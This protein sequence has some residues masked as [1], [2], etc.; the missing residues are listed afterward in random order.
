MTTLARPAYHRLSE[1][2]LIALGLAVL[3]VPTFTALA[4]TLWQDEEYAHGP[5]VLAIVIWMLWRTREGWLN[6]TPRPRPVQ[7]WSSLVF[8]LL[9]YIVGRSQEIVI[10][11]VG[12]MVPIL[13]GIFLILRGW[14]S[15]SAAWF[16]L[17]FVAFLV[18]VPSFVVDS[19]TGPLKESVSSIAETVLYTAGY[20]I[21]H[22]G[23]TLTIGQYQL[24]VAD[25]CSG[26]HSMFSL[27][28][29]GLLYIY[30][31]QYKQWWR[32][33]IL[34]TTILPT[35]F[36]ANIVRVMILVLVTYHFGDEAGQGFVHGA[37]GM[38]LFIIALL[39]LIMLDGLIGTMKRLATGK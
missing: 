27:S 6:V 3:Y 23:V 25:A 12:S 33:A 28:A 2:S 1:W 16:P 9:T 19:V 38:V 20:P 14:E 31:M 15:V 34:A 21:A 5:I 24:L 11:E 7:G 36:F 26:L 13:V 18:P 10:F 8:G 30:L 35:A 37:A 29:L 32:N 39:V 22:S 17:M 4:R